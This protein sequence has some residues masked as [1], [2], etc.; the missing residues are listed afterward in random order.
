[1]GRRRKT[2]EREGE[3]QLPD[4]H[5]SVE[6]RAG[7]KEEEDGAGGGW[8]GGRGRE[9]QSFQTL[10]VCRVPYRCQTGRHLTR[11][12]VVVLWIEMF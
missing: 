7:R 4:P 9:L 5:R 6:Y 10:T 1:M 2:A 12:T 3:G 11:V 8:V